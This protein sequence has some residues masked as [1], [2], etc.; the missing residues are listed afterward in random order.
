MPG[1]TLQ[2]LERIGRRH[3]ATAIR[4]GKTIGLLPYLPVNACSQNIQIL[5]RIAFNF[6]QKAPKPGAVLQN[7]V[8][9]LPS[10]I[11]HN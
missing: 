6:S 4:T 8:L 7:I 3:I 11:R 10:D 5:W 9:K 1:N 2:V